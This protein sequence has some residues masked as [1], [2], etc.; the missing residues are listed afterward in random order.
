[1]TQEIIASNIK[2]ILQ[3]SGLK[4]AAVAKRA[5]LTEQQLSYMLNGRKL[6]REEHIPAISAALGVSCREVFGE[7]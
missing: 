4:Q 3:Q 6:I 1:M 2:H 7:K 5:G